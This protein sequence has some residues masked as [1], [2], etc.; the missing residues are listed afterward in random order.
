MAIVSYTLET[1]P[2]ATEED[3]ARFDAMTEDDID[4]SDIPKITSM[5]VLKL[6]PRRAISKQQDEP[7]SR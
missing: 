6:R 5:K 1:L 3:L 4:F 7:Q 2:K